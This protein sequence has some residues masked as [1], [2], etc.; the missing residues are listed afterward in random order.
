MA[1]H[2]AER[3][4]NKPMMVCAHCQTEKPLKMRR[5]RSFIR[6]HR[7]CSKMCADAAKRQDAVVDKNGYRRFGS[8]ARFG[9]GSV[10]EHRQLMA[11]KLGRDLLPT[12]TV[13]HRDG[14]RA[15]NSDGN[16]ELWSSSHPRGQRVIEKVQWA[17]EILKQYP[18]FAED[19]GYQIVSTD[20][21]MTENELI[22]R[23]IVGQLN[24]PN[25]I[26][27]FE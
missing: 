18:E 13:H 27:G 22:E 5:D 24:A 25:Y 19:E 20:K 10:L 26:G 1:C 9:G 3:D 6:G 7:Y 23:P 12:E 16:L 21:N 14:Q 2:K 11:A 15:N 17:I 8:A 4:A